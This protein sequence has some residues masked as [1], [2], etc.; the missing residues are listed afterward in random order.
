MKNY[1][2]AIP[3]DIDELSLIAAKKWIDNN[4]SFNDNADKVFEMESSVQVLN[5]FNNRIH[6]SVTKSNA[7][8]PRDNLLALNW[9]DWRILTRYVICFLLFAQGSSYSRMAT[10]LSVSILYFVVEMGLIAL[11]MERLGHEDDNANNNEGANQNNLRGAGVIH[12]NRPPGVGG[13]IGSLIVSYITE[14]SRNGCPV[15]REPGI[16]NDIYSFLMA[17]VFSL[18]PNWN[19]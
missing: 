14:I 2:V 16:L 6:N 8:A 17:F 11:I 18:I 1:N 3:V 4:N 9:F 5:E 10:F 7:P 12:P 19:V 13:G 15:P